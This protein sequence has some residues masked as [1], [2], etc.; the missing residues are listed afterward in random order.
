MSKKIEGS[1]IM[2]LMTDLINGDITK[3]TRF[4]PYEQPDIDPQEIWNYLESC[5]PGRTKA[6]TV[7]LCGAKFVTYGVTEKETTPYIYYEVRTKIL[8]NYTE[9][10]KF[11][12]HTAAL[13]YMKANFKPKKNIYK[14]WC[15]VEE[16]IAEGIEIPVDAKVWV[17]LRDD[18]IS[19]KRYFSHIDNKTLQ[20]FDL[21]TASWTALKDT[22]GWKYIKLHKEEDN[23]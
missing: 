18:A 21:G 5:F 22:S 12:T 1:T 7:N 11:T 9:L 2:C 10:K 6:V 13:A 20:C 4:I 19:E 14:D 23:E 15:T 8:F 3:D 17:K 16:V